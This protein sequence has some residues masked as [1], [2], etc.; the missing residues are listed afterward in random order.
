MLHDEINTN[1]EVKI[2]FYR[3]YILPRVNIKNCNLENDGRNFYDQ[4]I[5]KYYEVRKKVIAQGDD[6]TTCYLLDYGYFGKSYKLIASHLSK[7]KA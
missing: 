7:Q 3:K 5:K 1:N 2:D 4:P 6:Y